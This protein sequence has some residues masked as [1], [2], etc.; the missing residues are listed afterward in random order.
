MNKKIIS[1]IDILFKPYEGSKSVSELKNDILIDLNDRYLDLLQQ[2]INEEMALTKTL[3]S[4]GEIEKTLIEITNCPP[5]KQNQIKF[6]GTDLKRS[7]FSNIVL[8]NGVMTSSNLQN[9]NFSSSDLTGSNFKT[10]D[11]ENSHFDYA[12]LTNCNFSITNLNNASFNNSIL[13]QT[14]FNKSTLENVK[15][16][17]LKLINV[18]FSIIDL[19]NVVFDNCII[20]GG[21]FDCADLR[22]QN[23]DNQI[24]RNVHIGKA[25]LENISFKGATLNNVSFKPRMSI[26]NKYYKALATINF[27]G[28]FIDKITY[29][30]LKSVGANLNNVTIV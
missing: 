14:N 27:D 8:H 24:I 21:N 9:A 12:N 3:E 5:Q 16:K 29:N 26:T 4:I 25:I 17:N 19:R 6:N 11:L 13:K 30:Y 18:N 22:N 7:D 15:F 23:F 10:C 28:A 1:Y 20:D 2:G